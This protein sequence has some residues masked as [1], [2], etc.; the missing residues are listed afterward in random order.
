M[1]RKALLRDNHP[2][3]LA[4]S[5]GPPLHS[6]PPPIPGPLGPLP[7]MPPPMGVG[8]PALRLPK[9]PPVGGDMLSNF[10]HSGPIGRT[11]FVANVSN[12]FI[13]N[14]ELKILMKC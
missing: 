9:L 11:V 2:A 1:C 7:P 5:V 14:N 10:N 4:M 12:L 6:M 3:A 13:T 8:P